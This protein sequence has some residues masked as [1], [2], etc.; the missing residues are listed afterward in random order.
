MLNMASHCV[1]GRP[2]SCDVPRGY[3]SS[4]GFLRPCGKTMLN[5][6]TEMRA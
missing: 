2:A 5:I 3:D 6:L 1:L 4:P